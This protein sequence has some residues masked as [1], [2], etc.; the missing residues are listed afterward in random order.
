MYNSIVLCASQ[1]EGCNEGFGNLTSPQKGRSCTICEKT[2][3]HL[4]RYGVIASLYA[5]FSWFL[6][7]ISYFYMKLL[8][9][10]QPLE[11]STT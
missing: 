7:V 5:L 10:N 4:E 6:F 2:K 9:H 11:E 8:V 1:A 3:N